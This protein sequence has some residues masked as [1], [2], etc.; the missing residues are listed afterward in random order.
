MTQLYS[1]LKFK[2]LTIENLV[3]FNIPSNLFAVVR[4]L[5]IYSQVLT[6]NAYKTKL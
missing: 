4:F 1:I 6:A 3:N 5:I 2:T